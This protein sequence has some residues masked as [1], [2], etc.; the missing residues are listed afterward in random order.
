MQKLSEVIAEWERPYL[1]KVRSCNCF[2]YTDKS[3]QL[4]IRR[5]YLVCYYFLL[6]IRLGIL[7][8]SKFPTRN[9]WH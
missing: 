5:P 7:I 8:L 9:D 3:I 1:S 6:L 2:G 4:T